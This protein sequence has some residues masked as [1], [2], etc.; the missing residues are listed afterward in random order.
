MP[1]KTPAGLFFAIG[2]LAAWMLA[3]LTISARADAQTAGVTVKVRTPQEIINALQTASSTR[4]PTT[5]I[6]A[7]GRYH[8]TRSFDTGFGPGVLPVVRGTV[9]VVGS[10]AST[11]IFDA[12][13]GGRHFTVAPAGQLVLRK[14]TLTEGGVNAPA[15]ELGGGAI[16]NFGGFVRLDDCVLSNN[17]AAMEEGT[18][19]GA[20]LSWKGRLHLERTQLTDNFVEN[21]G[22][23]VAIFD[24]S[25]IIR[26]S[27]I[28]G[29]F[30]QSFF[31]SG[32]GGGVLIG[33]ATVTITGSTISGNHAMR[34]GGGI[35]SGGQLWIT[36]SA[37]VEN[38]ALNETEQEVAFGGGIYNSGQLRIKN[39]TV[40][41]NTAGTF[42]GGIF[43]EGGLVVLRGATITENEVLGSLDLDAVIDPR[44]CIPIGGACWGGGGIWNLSRGVQGTV[45]MARTILTDNTI[46]ENDNPRAVGADCGG[47]I[48]SE[49][50]NAVGNIT[51]C[52]LRPS[53][54]LQGRPTNDRIGVDP[55]LDELQ[56]NGE[57]GDAHFPL[58]ADSPLIDAD[59]PV[60]NIC[61]FLDQIGRRRVDAD[62]DGVRQCDIGAVEFQSP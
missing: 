23:G 57:P 25:A 58:L 30:A 29:N 20:I 19:G 14:L 38:V 10:S 41:A 2:T 4:V 42:G 22:G 62:G 37:V 17:H 34:D 47:P 32:S 26:D 6:V 12:D 18:V 21:G 15:F 8:F 48:L 1:Q 51:E 5:V 40:G 13:A 46:R 43:N 61:T 33:S 9:F 28:S 50:Y 44:R 39:G 55:R 36:D 56:D 31:G 24:G 49:G 60:S 54:V 53:Y 11:T 45:T 35:L 16:L 3:T 7:P 27:I 52:A 59:G